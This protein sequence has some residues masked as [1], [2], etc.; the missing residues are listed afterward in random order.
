[1]EEAKNV[2]SMTIQ[3][4][5]K[6]DNVNK[7]KRELDSNYDTLEGNYAIMRLSIL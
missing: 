2:V 7:K 4:H 6:I 1:V 3:T 5:E